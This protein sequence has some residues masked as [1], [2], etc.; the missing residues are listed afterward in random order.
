MTKNDDIIICQ[1]ESVKHNIVF[2]YVQEEDKPK[3]WDSVYMNV[4]LNG[5]G[6]WDRLSRFF[7][8]V[9]YGSSLYGEYDEIVLPPEQE[10]IDKL[11]NV[12]SYLKKI[13]EAK[14]EQN[15]K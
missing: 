5:K 7:D 15:N 1:C 12:V 13:K 10:T 2:R 6:F 9:L 14:D 11:E 4:H 3:Y 8:Y